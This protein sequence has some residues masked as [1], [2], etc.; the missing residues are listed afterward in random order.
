M[1]AYFSNLHVRKNDT[2]PSRLVSFIT[3]YF[4]GK[5][6]I[7]ANPD[8]AD[9]QIAL[10]APEGSDWVSVCSE[11]FTHTDILAIAPGLSEACEADVLNIACFDSDY[12]FLNLLNA[13]Q[14]LD[15][16]LNVG[17][18]PEIKKPRRNSVAGWK[19]HVADHGRFKAAAGKDYV[20]AEDFLLEVQDDLGIPAGRCAEYD[21]PE[22]TDVL[23]FS[24]PAKAAVLP[25][26][27]TIP[28]Y[29][30]KPCEPGKRAACSVLNQGAA[31]KG[32]CILFTGDYVASE[33]ITIDDAEFFYTDKRGQSVSIPITF[34]KREWRENLWVYC[35]EDE[36]FPIPPAV[37]DGL[38]PQVKMKKEFARSFGIR[39]VPNG[40]KRKFLDITVV[41]APL[42]NFEKGQCAWRVWSRAG[43]KRDFIREKNQSALRQRAY[44]VPDE[45]IAKDLIDESD[46][47]LD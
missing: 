11:A 46:Y 9:M 28:M 26:K 38:P 23:Y 21:L 14:G 33:D 7:S 25:T 34:E 20:C 32:I 5:G 1:G 3:E 37:S 15:L 24:A 29:D 30:L 6:Y 12:L 17:D 36:S 4:A 44:G 45:W 39:Y 13:K 42:S 8:T 10:Y 16:W 35:W 47:D 41:F 31:S 22:A 18:T 43:S 19:G 27:L 40:N 2:D